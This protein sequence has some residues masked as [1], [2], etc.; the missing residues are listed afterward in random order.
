MRLEDMLPKPNF[1]TVAVAQLEQE[2]KSPTVSPITPV[3]RVDSSGLP[4]DDYF[5]LT[6]PAHKVQFWKM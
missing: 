5:S 3:E 2:I 1:P 4:L 6:E